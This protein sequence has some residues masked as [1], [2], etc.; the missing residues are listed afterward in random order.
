MCTQVYGNNDKSDIRNQADLQAA[1][2]D[3]FFQ[4]QV[5]MTWYASSFSALLL[6]S[7]CSHIA[8][9]QAASMTSSSSTRLT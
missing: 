6:Q 9:L 2:D 7:Y 5:D 3:I 8:D 4:Y 1:F